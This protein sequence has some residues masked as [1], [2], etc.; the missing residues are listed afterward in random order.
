MENKYKKLD[1]NEIFNDEKISISKERIDSD[2]N[3]E[4]DIKEYSI[5]IDHYKKTNL[6][7]RKLVY[8]IK[9]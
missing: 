9:R 8:E 1:H 2:K 6:K 7:I 5:A 4:N 3:I